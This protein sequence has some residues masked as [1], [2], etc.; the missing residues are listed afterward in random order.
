MNKWNAV[1]TGGNGCEAFKSI[2]NMRINQGIELK[3]A[4]ASFHH[5][6]MI[7]GSFENFSEKPRRA[8]VINVF[9]DGVGSDTNEPLSKVVTVNP[10]DEKITA[11]F[12]Y[13]LGDI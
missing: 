3:A 13:S 4:K 8:A 5:P 6:L 2:F 9:R 7:H 1:I 12:R 10:K 11:V